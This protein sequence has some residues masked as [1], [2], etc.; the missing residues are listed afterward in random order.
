MKFINEDFSYYLSPDKNTE[1]LIGLKQYFEE[2]ISD[3]KKNNISDIPE[4][5]KF[6]SSSIIGTLM[7]ELLRNDNIEYDTKTKKN[8]EY[9]KYYLNKCIEN[10]N[11]CN[12]KIF[13]SCI[14]ECMSL[15]LPKSIYHINNVYTLKQKT[16]Y[17]IIHSD[18]EDK[19]DIIYNNKENIEFAKIYFC[20]SIEELFICSLYELFEKGYVIRKCKSCKKFFVTRETGNRI[21][22]C[23]NTS[24]H[25]PNKTCYEYF[26]QATYT[27]KRKD[28]AIRALYG[29]LYSKYH[30]RYTRA[31]DASPEKYSQEKEQQTQKDYED[32]ISIYAKMGEFLNMKKATEEEIETDL[33]NYE[34]GGKEKWQLKN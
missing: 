9:F 19:T 5:S 23:Y 32:F 8:L 29:K 15:S 18:K 14:Q 4:S 17:D 27:Q 25:N 31:Q 33:I 12:N 13:L 21:K 2:Y 3:S 26:S 34:K 30:N 10:K 28:D 22:Y 1:A 11:Y 24:L 7:F 16:N 6:I 20:K